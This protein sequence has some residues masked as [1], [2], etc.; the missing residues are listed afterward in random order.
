MTIKKAIQPSK[1][2]PKHEADPLLCA[3]TA[4]EMKRHGLK[5]ANFF[6]WLDGCP[7]G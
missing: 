4:E 5:H 1:F 7:S 6:F 3:P 2:L